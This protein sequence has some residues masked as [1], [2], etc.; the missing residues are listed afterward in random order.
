MDVCVQVCGVG[1]GGV[2]DNQG[3]VGGGGHFED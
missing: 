2:A 3:G 1:G